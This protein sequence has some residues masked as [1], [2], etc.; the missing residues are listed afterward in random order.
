MMNLP[1]D[2]REQ[3]ADE[4]KNALCLDLSDAEI[5]GGTNP[6]RDLTEKKVIIKL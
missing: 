1:E 3:L 5:S 6:Q 2:K 4:L